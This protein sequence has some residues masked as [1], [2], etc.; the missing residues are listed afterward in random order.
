MSFSRLKNLLPLLTLTAIAVPAG[1]AAAGIGV[2]PGTLEMEAYP[3]VPDTAIV[4][5]INTSAE[6]SLCQ[7]YIEGEAS[8]W[9][10]IE[11]AEF[12]LGP[13]ENG[14]VEITAEPPLGT[15]GEYEVKVCAV[16]LSPAS[17]LKVGCGVKVPLQL[18]VGLAPPAGRIAELLTGPYL[19]WLIIA[20]VAVVVIVPIVIHRRRRRAL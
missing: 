16:A 3:L 10:T 20:V 4:T 6:E 14:T 11:P 17:G 7:V 12:V 19:K 13:N 8:K 15:R 18:N 1:A 5:V 2:M 9:F